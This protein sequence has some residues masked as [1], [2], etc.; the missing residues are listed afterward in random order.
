MG[1]N[2]VLSSDLSQPGQAQRVYAFCHENYLHISHLINNAGF[3]DYKPIAETKAKVYTEM[4]NLNVITLTE[5]TTL[6]I[7][8]MISR[9][10]TQ[11]LNVASTAA[12]QPVPRLAVYSAFKSYVVYFT[13][14]LHEELYSSGVTATV[15][16][17]GPTNTGF[18]D[19]AVMN[20]ANLG[21]DGQADARSVAL[22]GCNAMMIGRLYVVPGI[23][24]NILALSTRIVPSRRVVLAISNQVS[25]PKK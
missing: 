21:H 4:L 15:L 16:S 18:R 11:I 2:V 13:E 1:V 10:Y 14:A 20:N 17:L 24:N 3:G 12:Y 5:L 9:G 19:R 22:A 8:H 23:G 6:F 7:N 25:K